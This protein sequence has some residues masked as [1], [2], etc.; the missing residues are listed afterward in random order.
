M[1]DPN[2]PRMMFHRAHDPVT[3]HSEYEEEQLGPEWSRT[4]PAPVP[5]VREA[6]P[7]PKAEAPK[8]L[9]PPHKPAHKPLLPHRKAK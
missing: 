5:T 8:A 4:I 1:P 6:S 9:P 3:V 7:P 2:Y